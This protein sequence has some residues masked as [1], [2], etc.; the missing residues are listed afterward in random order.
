MASCSRVSTPAGPPSAADAP[1]GEE[2]PPEQFN[3]TNPDLG[4]DADL[5]AAVE[6]DREEE[7]NVTAPVI[8][9]EPVGTNLQAPDTPTGRLEH[10]HRHR[11][12][13]RRGARD[14]LGRDRAALVERERE[15]RAC[16]A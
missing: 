16:A 6:V 5:P 7:L 3:L 9:E 12:A 2:S 13:E 11:I 15:P 1:G 10:R 8:Q 14:V 4:L